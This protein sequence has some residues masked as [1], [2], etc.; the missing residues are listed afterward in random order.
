MKLAFQAP[1]LDF[2]WL[3]T[4]IGFAKLLIGLVKVHWEPFHLSLRHRNYDWSAD[5]FG[6]SWGFKGFPLW[7]GMDWR[8]VIFLHEV[9]G[10][11]ENDVVEGFCLSEYDWDFHFELRI[12]TRCLGIEPG[13]ILRYF[14]AEWHG[15]DCTLHACINCRCHLWTDTSFKFI[16]FRIWQVIEP[17]SVKGNK[18]KS[19]YFWILRMKF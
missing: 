12:G 4:M 17:I 11:F 8:W 3:W 7:Q 13:E 18:L 9:H 15:L 16:K 14:G 6:S 1:E 5:S 2:D 19:K 10:S